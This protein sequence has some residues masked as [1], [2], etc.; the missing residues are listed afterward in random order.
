MIAKK[1][2]DPIGAAYVAFT[3]SL[4][5]G[6]KCAWLEEMYVSPEW[7]EQGFG[8]A[9]LNEVCERARSSG[10]SAIDLEVDKEH[11]RA[12]DLYQRERF[13]P[14]ARDRWVKRL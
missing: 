12:A 2:S 10:C 9:L 8:A 13:K 7:R 6:G 4:E 14:L 3:W 11:A 1:G 5:H